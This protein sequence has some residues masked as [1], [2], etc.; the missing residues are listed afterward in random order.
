M[1]DADYEYVISTYFRLNKRGAAK[2][3]AD[4][5]SSNPQI[6][7]RQKEYLVEEFL[8]QQYQDKEAGFTTE[9]SLS[10]SEGREEKAIRDLVIA[11]LKGMYRRITKK[12]R[13]GRFLSGPERA[14]IARITDEINT[15]RMDFMP[16]LPYGYTF[17]DS[18]QGAAADIEALSQMFPPQEPSDGDR[19]SSVVGGSDINQDNITAEDIAAD[20]TRDKS[21]GAVLDGE[22]NDTNFSDAVDDAFDDDFVAAPSIGEM[23]T[24]DKEDILSNLVGKEKFIIFGDRMRVGEYKGINNDFDTPIEVQGVLVT[25]SQ[26]GM[27]GKRDGPQIFQRRGKLCGRQDRRMVLHWLRFL[28]RVT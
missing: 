6:V 5:K 18:P 4:L 1:S 19:V 20:N 26:R 28:S 24:W 3:R 9:D 23:P 2:A 21:H 7:K 17:D 14:A 25:P 8:R 16:S 10:T 11:Y 27:R 22:V 15:L 13:N 12:T